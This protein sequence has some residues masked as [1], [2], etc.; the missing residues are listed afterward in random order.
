MDDRNGYSVAFSELASSFVKKNWKSVSTVL[1][2]DRE[3][4]VTKDDGSTAVIFLENAWREYV[5]GIAIDDVFEKYLLRDSV[6][7]EPKGDLSDLVPLIKS[8]EFVDHMNMHGPIMVEPLVSGVWIVYARDLGN[9]LIYV[10]NADT[11]LS[12]VDRTRIRV[13]SVNNLKRKTEKFIQVRG[14]GPIFMITCGGNYESSL[15]LTDEIWRDLGEVVAG[16]PARDLLLFTSRQSSE[17]LRLLQKTVEQAF[18]QSDH[19]VTRNLLMRS[20]GMWS[21]F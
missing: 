18:E 4:L 1:I 15:L 20:N 19:V 7:T 2:G 5:Q 17:G 9:E 13:T 12:S 21:L 10:K 11:L 6:R 3:L 16:I 8:D 14:S